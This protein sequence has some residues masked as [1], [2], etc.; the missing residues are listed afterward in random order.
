MSERRVSSYYYPPDFDPSRGSLN[1]QRGRVRSSTIRFALPMTC[2]CTRCQSLLYGGSRFNATK[3]DSG[4]W[5]NIKLWE[6]HFTCSCGNLCVIKTDPENHGYKTVQGLQVKAGHQVR[7]DNEQDEKQKNSM[8][9]LDSGAVKGVRER[10][11]K[12]AELVSLF[13]AKER[14]GSEFEL[15]LRVRNQLRQQ[16]KSS[17]S[18]KQ[19]ARKLHILNEEAELAGLSEEE[20]RQVNLANLLFS[21]NSSDSIAS[22]N[23]FGIGKLI[24]KAQQTRIRVVDQSQTE[25]QRETRKRK[26]EIVIS[27]SENEKSQAIENEQMM[28]NKKSKRIKKTQ[29][30]SSI[31]GSSNDKQEE[32]VSNKQIIT[33]ID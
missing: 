30:P 17:E 8:E 9:L 14:I 10:K 5:L 7:Y 16:R 3:C 26:E 25:K 4:K 20:E 23:D 31:S 21:H 19:Q 29:N 2:W 24:Q 15:G 27:D 32:K 13:H 6:F 22:F 18:L 11:E 1:T 12:E 33:I 28:N